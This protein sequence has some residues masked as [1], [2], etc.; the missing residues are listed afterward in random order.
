MYI[1]YRNL[2]IV[3]VYYIDTYYC[4]VLYIYIYCT[5]LPSRRPSRARRFR[6][7][8]YVFIVRRRQQRYDDDDDIII[9]ISKH[10]VIFAPDTGTRLSVRFLHFIFTKHMYYYYYLGASLLR[11]FPTAAGGQVSRARDDTINYAFSLRAHPSPITIVPSP[12]RRCCR[13][14]R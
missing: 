6:V 2:C 7:I 10:I 13:T 1:V 11:S 4:T 3:A 8:Y 12:A 5:S 9:I 14:R